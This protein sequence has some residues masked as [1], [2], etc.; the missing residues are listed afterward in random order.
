MRLDRRLLGWGAF[1]VLLGAIPLA[2]R[3]GLLD[4]GL[5]ER[6]PTL[7]PLLPIGWGLSLIF[8][9]TPIDWLG[10]AVSTVTLGVM[11]GG[12][13]VTGFGG[14]PAIG[15]GDGRGSTAFETRTGDLGGSG[16]LEL[17]FDCGTLAVVAGDGASWTISGKDEDGRG[18]SVETLGDRVRIVDDRP[19]AFNFGAAGSDWTVTVPRG[20]SLD[21]GLTLNAGEGTI[22]LSGVALRSTNFTLNAG[23]LTFDLGDSATLASMNGTVNAGAADVRL[24]DFGGSV[25]LSINAGSVDLCV[26]PGTEFRIHWSGALA[27]H[28]LDGLGLAKLDGETWATAGYGSSADAVDMNVS[29][30]AGSFALRL[31]G[32]CGG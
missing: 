26:P 12:L 9:R 22:D 27:S 20:P 8:R 13:I 19:G 2:S 14:L 3:A 17:E 30:S 16:R 28:N 5:L 31:G 4:A 25:N 7:W 15:C 10:G 29:A 1:F 6:W 11:G 23:S 24:P 32:A 21:V 18:P